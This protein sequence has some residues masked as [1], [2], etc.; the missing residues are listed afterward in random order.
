MFSTIPNVIIYFLCILQPDI[1]IFQ[2]L[3]CINT[4]ITTG[5]HFVL[6]TITIITV[7]QT[8][9]FFYLLLC[10]LLLLLGLGPRIDTI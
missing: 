3:A 1:D 2:S 8:L 7:T 6:F 10:F 5:T 9:T 4:N